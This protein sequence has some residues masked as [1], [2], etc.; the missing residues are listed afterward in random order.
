M[1]TVLIGGGVAGLFFANLYDGD[2]I[3]V[4]KNEVAG[5]KLLAT[6]LQVRRLV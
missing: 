2:L 6:G 3:I 4:E 1:K 5:R